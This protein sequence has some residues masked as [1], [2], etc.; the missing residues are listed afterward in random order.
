MLDGAYVRV[1]GGGGGCAAPHG[2]ALRAASPPRLYGCR[3]RGALCRA[4]SVPAWAAAYDP[5]PPP[6]RVALAALPRF[7]GLHPTVSSFP[8]PFPC[9]ARRAAR[10]GE[11][12]GVPKR[13][14]KKK[15]KKKT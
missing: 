4:A 14:E 8:P 5:C 7:G 2:G 9:V 15:K 3:G 13:V 10:G 1:V 11:R 12:A 6:P